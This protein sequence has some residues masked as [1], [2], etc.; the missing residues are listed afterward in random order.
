MAAPQIAFVVLISEPVSRLVRGSP[1]TTL[2]GTC[3]PGDGQQDV[4]DSCTAN[5]LWEQAWAQWEAHSR[6]IG[7]T[8]LDKM[9]YVRGR[10][11]GSRGTG[12]AAPIQAR[13]LS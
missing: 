7:S 3:R 6:G 4:S 9:G 2:S 1:G 8:L 13:A 11:L 5:L 12:M 10:G